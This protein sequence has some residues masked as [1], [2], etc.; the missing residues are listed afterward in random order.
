M[1]RSAPAEGYDFGPKR[2]YRRAVWNSFRDFTGSDTAT[3]HALLMPS[4][5]GDEIEIAIAKGFRQEHLHVVDRNPAIVAHLK[6]RFPKIH[7]YGVDVERASERIVSDGFRLSCANLD[8]CGTYEH[9]KPTLG[10]FMRSGCMGGRARV[11]VT[12][13]RGRES[14]PDGLVRTWGRAGKSFRV[15]S[16]RVSGS[17]VVGAGN[18]DGARALDLLSGLLEMTP[19]A[20][21]LQNVSK[22]PSIAGTQTMMWCVVDLYSDAWI[23]KAWLDLR[24][25][26]SDGITESNK[27]VAVERIRDADMWWR[28]LCPCMPDGATAR[29]VLPQLLLV[30]PETI[31]A[32]VYSGM[33]FGWKWDSFDKAGKQVASG[34]SGVEHHVH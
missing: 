1:N 11:A 12:G 29:E 15:A 27:V 10:A 9:N 7:T 6:R 14:Q 33:L 31:R 17:P 3:A 34:P 22:Y 30:S 23:K 19:Y 18:R 16:S 26:F 2:N 28:L 8:L 21:K 4:I 13:L 20:A 24:A 5:E 25:A 32:T